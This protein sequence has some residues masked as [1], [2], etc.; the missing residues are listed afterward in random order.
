MSSA[1]YVPVA[2]TSRHSSSAV[3]RRGRA[4][5]RRRPA[6]AAAS[7]LRSI[8]GVA[9]PCG[10]RAGGTA[11]RRA[12]RR[13]RPSSDHRRGRTDP[14]PAEQEPQRPHRGE[15]IRRRA[16]DLATG[17]HLD[18]AVTTTPLADRYGRV[19]TDLR[20]SLTDRCN[21]RCSYCMPAEGLDW[22]PDDER[23]HR[24]R[25]RPADRHRRAA[26]RR[27]RGAVHRRRAAGAPRAG[28]H[29]APHQGARPDA[30]DLADHQRARPRPHRAARS[31]D[32]GLDRVN[33]SLDTRP[34]ARRST[35]SP[36]ATGSTT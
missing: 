20:V 11:T 3:D 18:C 25:G 17:P 28:R 13:R 22:L 12:T 5:A 6:P 24:R 31:R 19:A 16:A 27:P 8:D 4:R 9:R 21:L 33:V 14:A 15:A 2:V 36:A 23:A 30:R 29:R 10:P 35:R 26:A 34:A 7:S 1:S 32:A